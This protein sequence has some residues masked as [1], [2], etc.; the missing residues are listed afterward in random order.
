MGLREY[1]AHRGV[2]Q[3]SV[4]E[5]IKLGKISDAVVIKRG[6]KKI[7]IKKAD[8]LWAQ[9]TLP[10]NRNSD[11]VASNPTAQGYAKAR[12][13]KEAYAA[14]IAQLNYEQKSGKLCRVD[15]IKRAASETARVTR[16]SL[17]SLPDRL[18]PL[19]AAET[20][21]NDIKDLLIE[22]ISKSLQNISQIDWTSIMEKGK[23][24]E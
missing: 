23:S 4:S 18:A 8:I 6:L 12:A 22:E 13:A 2:S 14:R 24:G 10:N 17:L 3:S 21:L 19:L 11:Q 20:D 9:N 15:D 1:A 5:A 7:D 16:D